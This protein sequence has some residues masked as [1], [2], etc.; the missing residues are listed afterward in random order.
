MNFSR[1]WYT[2]SDSMRYESGEIHVF[3]C[4]FIEFGSDQLRVKVLKTKNTILTVHIDAFFLLGF[5]VS[6][7]SQKQKVKICLLN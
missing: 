7:G 4:I 3:I 1:F 6:R 2:R 5:K